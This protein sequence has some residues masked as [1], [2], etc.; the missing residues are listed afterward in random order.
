M[1]FRIELDKEIKPIRPPLYRPGPII[2][3]SPFKNE[4]NHE[5]DKSDCFADDNTVST[6]FE[7]ESLKALKNILSEFRQLSGLCTN[8]EKTALLRIGDMQGDIPV[9]IV[10]MGFTI[11][12][13]IKLLSFTISNEDDILERNFHPV[14]QKIENTIRFWERFYLSLAGK[15]TVYKT[16]LLPQLNYIGTILMPSENMLAEL[17]DTMEK[18]VTTGFQIA[19]KRLYTPTSEGGIGLFNLKTFL[20]ALQST[21]VKRAFD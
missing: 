6:V 4:S 13:S 16:L 10:E 19:K 7:L 8:Y 11:A 14:K 21:M 18:F 15:I 20:I 3:S 9:E 1:L 5:T 17:S 12:D 2:P